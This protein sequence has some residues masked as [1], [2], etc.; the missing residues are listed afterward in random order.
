[1]GEESKTFDITEGLY[2]IPCSPDEKLH[3]TGSHCLSCGEIYFPRKEKNFCV[4]CHKKTL[5]E[6]KLSRKGRISSFTVA[7]QPPAGGFYKGPVPFA[8]G[9]V[10]L[11]E[12]VRVETQFAGDFEHL[13]IGLEV[14]LSL[15]K[16]YE[17]TEGNK[18]V[19]YMFK[20]VEGQVVKK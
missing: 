2:T 18:Y 19:T 9:F 3:L 16:L 14:E 13:Q 15:E 5:G 7:S 8:Y 1:M 12:E 20:P 4:N 11:P 10:D 17:D 6:I